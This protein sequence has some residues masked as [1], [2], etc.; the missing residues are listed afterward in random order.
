MKYQIAINHL[1]TDNLINST[2]NDYNEEDLEKAKR[3]LEMVAKGEV[4]Y[5]EIEDENGNIAFISEYILKESIP[6]LIRRED[7]E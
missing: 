2:V 3:A 7:L 6:M 1:P 4:K 5:M